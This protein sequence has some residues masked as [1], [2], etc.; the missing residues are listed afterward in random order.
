MEIAG[1]GEV[2]P[3]Q[4]RT[5]HHALAGDQAAA[6]EAGEDRACDPGHRERHDEAGKQGEQQHQRE[7]WAE[8][9]EHDAKFLR[10]VQK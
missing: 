10:F 3:D 6:G 1:G 7:G 5:D 2:L 4:G 9:R 8:M